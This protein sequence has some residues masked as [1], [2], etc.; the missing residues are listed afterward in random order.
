MT[1]PATPII[2]T[3]TTQAVKI[4]SAHGFPQWI[5]SKKLLR[6]PTRK[7][8]NIRLNPKEY[9]PPKRFPLMPAKTSEPRNRNAPAPRK[10]S[11]EIKESI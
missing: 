11:T 6:N 3:L 4:L 9:H 7:K 8:P 1:C 5:S 2:Q 10:N